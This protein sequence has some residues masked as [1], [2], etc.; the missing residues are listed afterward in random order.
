MKKYPFQE[1]NAREAEVTSHSKT[2]MSTWL[3]RTLVVIFLLTI[4]NI[5]VNAQQPIRTQSNCISGLSLSG[6]VDH[7]TCF[8][9]SNGAIDLTITGGAPPFRINWSNGAKTEDIHN[10]S[11]GTYSVIVKDHLNC[12]A[13]AT[14]LVHQP[15]KIEIL[16][17]R[18]NSIC[19]DQVDGCLLIEGGTPPYLVWVFEGPV[20]NNSNPQFPTNGPPVLPGG[21]ISNVPFIQDPTSPQFMLCAQDIPAGYYFILVVDNNGCYALKRITIPAANL[22]VVLGVVSDVS[23][24]GG[25][26]GSIDITVSGGTPPYTYAWSNGNTSED[27][28]NVSAG[29]YTVVV[30]DQNQCSVTATFTVGQPA[31][32]NITVILSYPICGGQPSGCA[33]ISGG[34]SPYQIWVFYGPPITNPQVDLSGTVPHIPGTQLNQNSAFTHPWP[35]YDSL[36]C[37]QNIPDGTYYILVID[38]NG[39]YTLEIVTIQGIPFMTLS[40]DITAVSCHN[41]L[42]GAI[43]LTV[44]HG[45]PPYSFIWSNGDATEDINNLSAGIYGVTVA[46]ANG[47]TVSGSYRVKQPRPLTANFLF[48]YPICGGQP[49]GCVYIGGG[50]SP[51][52]IWV[53]QGVLAQTHP[54]V[55]LNTLP[56]SIPG[57]TIVPAVQFTATSLTDSVL[58]ASNIPDGTYYVLIVDANG[59]WIL[60]T[61]TIQG[62]PFIRLKADIDHV[63]CAG[64][65]NGAI[66]LTVYH[67]TPPYS[68]SWSNGATSEDISNLQAGQYTV[69]VTDANGCSAS[70]TWGV[71]QPDSLN[72]NLTFHQYGFFACVNPTGGVLP[73][74]VIWFRLPNMVIINPGVTPFCVYN[75]TAGIYMVKVTD[76]N[77]CTKTEIFIIDPM[78]P[79]LGGEARVHPDTILSGQT[80]TFSLHYY[81]GNTIQWQFRTSFTGWIDIPGATSPVYVTPPIYT[82]SDKDIFV[83]AK[84]FCQ[85]TVPLFSTE[86]KLHIL[87]VAGQRVDIADEDLFNYSPKAKSTGVEELAGETM[88]SIQVFPTI[89]GGEFY[90]SFIGDFIEKTEIN[91]LDMTGRNIYLDIQDNLTDGSIVQ[92]SLGDM[93]K[94]FCLVRISNNGR[95]YTKKVIIH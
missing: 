24:Y 66:D 85:S 38:A 19:A 46:D 13:S 12:T 51:Y 42:D 8:G 41:G 4:L 40:A 70:E 68:F 79:C 69:T 76:A 9:Y 81:V 77:G 89:S 18:S 54:N 82:G 11:S 75:L 31:Q 16:F 3:W 29:N 78:P 95:V 25:S 14:F 84:V 90:I 22:V 36:I 34:T 91:V 6:Q 59:C 43:N 35:I 50:T 55:Q 52:S 58:C 74:S 57:L 83:R 86:A 26:D 21:T 80:S 88:Q 71:R 37:G 62:V 73:Y 1:L 64:G 30:F 33:Y 61:V 17:V 48:A 72:L 28:N 5:Q 20:A 53:F 10:L 65:S 44:H 27:L 94:G 2:D 67:G 32:L 56:P 63:S 15:D 49:S 7:V 87:A 60:E 23:C 47:C 45:N 93:A 92:V 39:C